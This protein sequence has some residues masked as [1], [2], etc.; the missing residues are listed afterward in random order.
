[1][2]LPAGRQLCH[3]GRPDVSVQEEPED[4]L[5]GGA[6]RRG[7][8]G[9]VQPAAELLRHLPHVRE[10]VRSADGCHSGDVQCHPARHR[11]PAEGAG[12]LQPALY[13]L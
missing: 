2:Q 4:G 9:A 6:H 3:S 5:R 7:G 13:L 12:H 1:M 10:R 11:Q 8:D